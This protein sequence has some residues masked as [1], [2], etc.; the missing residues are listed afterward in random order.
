MLLL[1]D[2]VEEPRF[3]EREDQSNNRYSGM[4]KIEE[5]LISLP[6]IKN[7]SYYWCEPDLTDEDRKTR[8]VNASKQLTDLLPHL[9]SSAYEIARR[10][11]ADALLGAAEL[12]QSLDAFPDTLIG[13][14]ASAQSEGRVSL[15]SALGLK[16]DGKDIIGLFGNSMTAY[17]K[18]N[19]ADIVAYIDSQVIA[20][21]TKVGRDLYKEWFRVDAYDGRYPLFSG[22]PCHVL[23]P[24]C[25]FLAIN[26]SSSAKQE[27]EA[28]MREAE[29]TFREEAGIPR[30]GE[31][32]ISETELYYAIKHSFP[33]LEVIHHA[34][35][36]WL[37][38]QHFD[39][40][41]P[42]INVA[43]EYQGI[44]HDVPV[45]FFGGAE[46]F[47]AAQKRDKRKFSLATRN[48]VRLIYV[49]EGYDL[50][51]L[52]NQIKGQR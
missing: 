13:S 46:A 27:A 44:Q 10:W 16:I 9:G 28:L 30:I 4:N 20:L 41:L 17:G 5:I 37:G 22:F 15:K 1:R 39:I 12:K 34:R 8:W 19:L 35:P 25:Q 3:N 43:I 45:E 21:Q 47:H 38:R 31:G 26:W 6:V 24:A 51:D 49:R 2:L 42:E 29:N 36:D 40:L 50:L 48:N 11:T 7:D 23:S 18:R 52:V 32:W 33:D 14:R